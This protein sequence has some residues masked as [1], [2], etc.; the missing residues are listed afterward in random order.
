[1]ILATSSGV[2]SR[3]SGIC[4]STIFSVPGDNIAVF[5]GTQQ[6]ADAWFTPS[7]TGSPSRLLSSGLRSDAFFFAIDMQVGADCLAK[8]LTKG[9]SIAAKDQKLLD[10]VRKFDSFVVGCPS[11]QQGQTQ[12]TYELNFTDRNKNALASLMEIAAAAAKAKNGN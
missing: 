10:I 11:G 7:T 12:V 2:P 1:M 9:D 4:C 5:S 8:V 6:R 3:C